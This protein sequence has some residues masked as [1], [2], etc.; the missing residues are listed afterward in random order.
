MCNILVTGGAGFIGSHLVDRLIKIGHNVVILDDLSTGKTKNLNR[1]ATFIP[2][3]L[4][5]VP[6]WVF[7]D[8]RFEYV[9]HLAAQINLRKSLENPYLD[10]RVNILG[11]VNIL[12]HS[13]RT[14]VKKIIFASSGGAIYSKNAPQPWTEKSIT[15]PESPYGLSKYS[16]EHY[17][18]I[19]K[20]IRGLDFAALR[21]SN[22]YGPRQNADGEAGVISIF[23]NRAVNN[24]DL[25]IFGDGFQT[26]DFV[27]VDDVVQANV[28]VLENNLSG[29]Y[30]VATEQVT[31]VNEVAKDILSLT[32]SD[33]KVIHADPVVGELR[34]T[35]LKS[36]KLRSTGW[37]PATNFTEGIAKTVKSLL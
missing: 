31:N 30:N 22:V 34:H 24:Q 1:R 3:G 23:A 16:T 15:E 4:N 13:A 8:N 7:E 21:Y 32:G 26:R 36:K 17:M 2:V 25:V 5:E 20:E 14:G 9:F 27:Y 35:S 6:A 12:E 29:V 28:H 37:A 19:F 33:S 11:S 10:A 18:R